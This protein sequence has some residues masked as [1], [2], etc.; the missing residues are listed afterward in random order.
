MKIGTL[1]EAQRSSLEGDEVE[2]FNGGIGRSK[3]T[4]WTTRNLRIRNTSIMQLRWWREP[5]HHGGHA[6]APSDQHQGHAMHGSPLWS[7]PNMLSTR[8]R[9]A[10]RSRRHGARYERSRHG[11]GDGAGH[12]APLLRRA[13]AGR[14]DRS[15]SLGA[16]FERRSGRP[17]ADD[18]MML[19]SR[20]RSCSGPVRFS[21]RA[22]G[23]R[24]ASRTLD[25]SVLIATGVLAAYGAS[26]GA[27]DG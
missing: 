20:R 15:S 27:D 14:P 22:P 18:W 2:R 10:C 3:G 19:I 21:S 25:M 8:C 17:V 23:Q 6:P 5:E 13:P 4:R 26:R 24:C 16:I 9:S 1:L 11:G 7:S 12:E